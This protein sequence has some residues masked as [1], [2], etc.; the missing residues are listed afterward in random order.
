MTWLIEMIIQNPVLWIICIIS[1][2]QREIIISKLVTLLHALLL[3]KE[4]LATIILVKHA[5]NLTGKTYNIKS[6]DVTS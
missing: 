2:S 6:F 3:A 1:F 5:S 4:K